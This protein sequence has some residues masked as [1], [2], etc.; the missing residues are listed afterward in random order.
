ME[1]EQA[2]WTLGASRLQ[3]FFRI[4]L[5]LC[6]PALAA[7][8]LLGWLRHERTRTT[9]AGRAVIPPQVASAVVRLSPLSREPGR[10]CEERLLARLVATAFTQRRKTLRNALATYFGA[11]DFTALGIDPGARPEELS[12]EDFVRATQYLASRPG[13]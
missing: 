3:T 2:A 9:T 10:Q 5:P 7:L 1:E 8:A 11:A 12:V 13:R 4:T 6:R